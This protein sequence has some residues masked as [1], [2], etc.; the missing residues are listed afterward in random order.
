M[1]ANR[2][3]ACF[4]YGHGDIPLG[5]LHE[6]DHYDALTSLK[7]L[8]GKSYICL[9]CLNAYNDLGRHACPNNKANFCGSC[10]QEGCEEHIDAYKHYRSATLECPQCHRFFYGQQCLD[11]HRM[12]SISGKPVGPDRPSVCVTRRKCPNCLKLSRATKEI[13]HHRCGHVQCRCYKEFVDVHQHKCYLQKAKTPEELRE[14]RRERRSQQPPRARRCTAAGLQTL[15][16]NDPSAADDE[17]FDLDEPVPPLHVFCD[18]ESM[19]VEGQHVPN[20]I[21]AETETDDFFE[22]YFDDCIPALQ[23]YQQW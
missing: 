23:S 20:L 18:I 14:E 16:A 17:D 7:G 4:A 3:Y 11:A 19:Q 8:F 5:L 2:A 12:K 10:M 1:D 9:H 13:Q 6:D 15:H 21:E 22:R